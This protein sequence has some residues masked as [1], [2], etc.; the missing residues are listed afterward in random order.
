MAKFVREQGIL[1]RYEIEGYGDDILYAIEAP[2]KNKTINNPLNN[3]ERIYG[4]V[5]GNKGEHVLDLNE[6]IGYTHRVAGSRG[7]RDSGS[8]S[9]KKIT[10]KTFRNLIPPI[11]GGY[12]IYT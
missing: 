11:L 12:G 6:D 9:S 2:E 1:P 8:R 10:R 5:L 3:I 4:Y 7:G